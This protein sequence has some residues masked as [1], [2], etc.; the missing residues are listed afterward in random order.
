MSNNFEWQTE[1]V[2]QWPEPAAV[3]PEPERRPRWRWLTLLV[4]VCLVAVAGWVVYRQVAQRVAAA[5]AATKMDVLS[6][7]NLVRQAAQQQDVEL[8]ATILSGRDRRWTA[9]QKT[10]VEDGLLQD[11]SVFGFQM[12]PATGIPVAAADNITITLSSDLTAAEVTWLEP[13]AVSESGAVTETVSLRQTGIYRQGARSWLL[14]PPERDFWGE[15]QQMSGAYVMLV[16]PERDEPLARR[17]IHDLDA[18]IVR[19]CTD[20]EGITCPA[21]L[22]LR[23]RLETDVRSVLAVHD[24]EMMLSGRN[25]TLPTPTLVGVPLDEAGYQALMRGYAAHIVSALITDLVGYECCVHAL[26][27]R[28]LLDKQLGQLGLRPWPLTEIGYEQLLSNPGSLRP[29]II[30]LW[31]RPSLNLAMATE[32]MP[33]YSLADFLLTQVTPDTA[34]AEVQRTLGRRVVFPVWFTRLTGAPYDAGA[35]SAG[36]LDFIYRRSA[37]ARVDLPVPLPEQKLGLVCSERNQGVWLYHYDWDSGNWRQEFGREYVP[38]PVSGY[39]YPLPGKSGYVLQ[40]AFFPTAQGEVRLS[41]WQEGREIFTLDQSPGVTD[42]TYP[43][44]FDGSDPT[45]RYLT[46]RT[47]GQRRDAHYQ[48]LDLASCSQGDCE[49]RS[50]P[51]RPL[52]SPDGAQTL[53]LSE[54]PVADGRHPYT[55]ADAEPDPWLS[56]LFRG[57]AQGQDVVALG[58]G[59]EPFWLDRETYGYLRRASNDVEVVT[60]A[61]GDDS[62]HV[63]LRAADLLPLI[64]P[65]G[66]VKLTVDTA[67]VNPAHARQVLVMTRTVAVDGRDVLTFFLLELAADGHSVAEITQIFETDSPASISGFSP[68]G[69]WLL[70][71]TWNDATRND[72]VHLIDL[73]GHE[74]QTFPA[75]AFRML[76]SADSQWLVQ[77]EGEYLLLRA[78]AY[79][80]KRLLLHDFSDCYS[81]HWV[82]D[83]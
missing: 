83:P 37:S 35:F 16:Y 42:S 69:R 65:A 49:T 67:L 11:R 2:E 76:W 80:Y 61:A 53:L 28:A 36:W 66:P 21:G 22:S 56:L 7:H 70:V 3:A 77:P 47:L 75:S 72:D 59:I 41:V 17:L 73:P 18:T 71:N 31:A 8:L 38:G 52:W 48:L 15:W 43:F 60:A 14:S 4:T 82:N 23:V 24:A 45:G 62:P 55:A 39:M 79:D 33:L 78:P 68:D 74:R 51:G 26:F 1:D 30:S 32:W 64:A 58:A 46:L 44:Y 25:L 50:L 13:F 57:D 54:P 81:A 10:L 5:S 27:Y 29:G 12:Q 6:V 63:I 19:V 40:E 9:V 20:L 34:V